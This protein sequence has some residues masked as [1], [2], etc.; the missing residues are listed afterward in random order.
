[1][2]SKSDSPVLIISNRLPITVSRSANGLERKPSAGGLVS[3]LDPVL[4]ARGG[5]WVG[6]PGAKLRPGESIDGDGDAYRMVPV[7][8]SDNEVTRYYHGFSNGT[9][10]P[11][12]HSMPDRTRFE[13]GDWDAYERVNALLKAL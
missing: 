3:A 2:N 5:T 4:R 10:W 12:F 11:L 8:L 1:M 13:R 7:E 9:L 6:W